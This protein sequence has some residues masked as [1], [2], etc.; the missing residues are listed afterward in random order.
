MQPEVKPA[1]GSSTSEFSCL[2]VHLFFG[3][4]IPSCHCLFLVLPIA[5][6][7]CRNHRQKLATVQRDGDL[8]EADVS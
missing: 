2:L 8:V 6:R 5:C 4:I 1:A 3:L 7:H